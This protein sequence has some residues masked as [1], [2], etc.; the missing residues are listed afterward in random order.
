MIPATARAGSVMDAPNKPAAGQEQVHLRGQKIIAALKEARVGYILSVPDLHTSHGLLRPIAE[1]DEFRL[2]RVCK[3][4]E[5][6]GIAAGLSYGNKRAVALIQYTGFLYSMNAIR[7][8]IQYNQPVVM[9]VGLLGKEPGTPPTKSRKFGVR[10]IEP[11][12]DVM[13]IPHQLIETDDDI[14]KI[15]LAI[16]EA[17][18]NSHPAVLL[19]GQ[20]PA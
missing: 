5:C 17:Y 19:I 1:D 13:G 9:M 7:G 4:D 6:I 11:I 18:E 2:V 8:V 3:E 10:I 15:A 20:R 14:H 16:D 12:I